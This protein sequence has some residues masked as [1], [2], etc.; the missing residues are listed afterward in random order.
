MIHCEVMTFDFGN[1]FTSL[2]HSVSYLFT[3][4]VEKV[5]ILDSRI[6]QSKSDE[7]ED[8]TNIMTIQS[9]YAPFREAPYDLDLY[10]RK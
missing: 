3:V 6:L 8:N 5:I 4:F 10:F 9:K 2:P 7:H 1:D